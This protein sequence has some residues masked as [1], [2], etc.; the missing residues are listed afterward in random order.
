[1]GSGGT[2]GPIATKTDVEGARHPEIAP[3][4]WHVGGGLLTQ[5]GVF[6]TK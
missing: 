3:D 5:S 2:R 1:M 4:V 6:C